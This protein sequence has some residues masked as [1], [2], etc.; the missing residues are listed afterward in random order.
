MKTRLLICLML[1]VVF[2]TACAQDIPAEDTAASSQTVETATE[3]PDVTTPT[4]PEVIAEIPDVTSPATVPT[5]AIEQDA[6][7]IADNFAFTLD[8]KDVTASLS[9]NVYRTSC[10]FQSDQRFIIESERPF[11]ALYIEWGTHPGLY[12]IIWDGGSLDCGTNGFL[13]EYIRLPEE[14]TSVEFLVACEEACNICDIALYTEGR[15]PKDVQ[16]WLPPCETADILVFPTHS[17]DDVLFFGAVISYYAIQENLDVQTAFMVDHWYEPDRKHERLDGLWAMGIRHYPI[18]GTVR[19]YM[20]TDLYQALV[21]HRN[22]KILDWQVEQIRRFKPLVVLGH[23]LGGEYGHGQHKVNAYYL[24]QAVDAASDPDQ[25]AE[26]AQLY[27]SWDTPKL[28]LHLYAEHEI[29]FDV[30][31]PIEND[32]KGRTAFEIAADAY[33]CH[34]SQQGYTF[35]VSQ[36][37]YSKLN[38]R[39]FGLYR[40]LV[41]YDST[42]DIMENIDRSQYRQ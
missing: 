25:F 4:A 18:L 34:V 33:K 32:E 16:E 20:S 21:F 35:K 14:T 26:S 27:G 3:I 36:E 10:S 40:S 1:C 15:A 24:T 29:F 30:N 23:D 37:E 17:D 42:A 9:D 5:D 19:D 31:T 2:T 6:E 28:Y 11:S 8:D 38:C 12:S 13:H 39:R 7:C 41:G 22:D